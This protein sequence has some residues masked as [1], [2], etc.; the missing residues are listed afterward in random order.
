MPAAHVGE[1]VDLLVARVLLVVEDF[2][3]G[4][5]ISGVEGTRALHEEPVRVLV[6]LTNDD[7]L[8]GEAAVVSMC[9]VV[10]LRVL[11]VD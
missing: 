2:A 11:Q 10:R 4:C 9:Q 6:S 5:A 7:V 8:L 3:S 1:G